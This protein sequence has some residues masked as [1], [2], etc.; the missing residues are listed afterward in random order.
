MWSHY[1]DSHNKSLRIWLDALDGDIEFTYFRC[2]ETDMND[3][4]KSMI[5]FL[6][7]FANE[8][9]YSKYQPKTIN[10]RENHV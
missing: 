9:R 1:D 6:Q 4:E 5:Q 8:H 3:L 10:W 7:P 2:A